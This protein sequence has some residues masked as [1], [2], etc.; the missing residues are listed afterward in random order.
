[1]SQGGRRQIWLFSYLST[2][3]SEICTQCLK[4]NKESFF[5]ISFIYLIF[6]GDYRIFSEKKTPFSPPTKKN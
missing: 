4:L 5:A 2:N 1:M 3:L 6:F